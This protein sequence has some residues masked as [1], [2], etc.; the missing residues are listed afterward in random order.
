[1][2]SYISNK[3]KTVGAHIK[4]QASRVGYVIAGQRD[5]TQRS[6]FNG[7]MRVSY[8]AGGLVIN[9]IGHAGK[10]LVGKRGDWQRPFFADGWDIFWGQFGRRKAFERVEK[11]LKAQGWPQDKEL[12]IDST[13]FEHEFKKH[14]HLNTVFNIVSL[15]GIPIGPLVSTKI[16]IFKPNP[17][18]WGLAAKYWGQSIALLKPK[19]KSIGVDLADTGRDV[20]RVFN[21]RVI[22]PLRKKEP[23]RQAPNK[24]RKS[25]HF[26]AE[27]AR[28]AFYKEMAKRGYKVP[29]K[30]LEPSYT[31]RQQNK[32]EEMIGYKKKT[33]KLGP[34]KFSW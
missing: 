24:T 15:V 5:T 27:L 28:G 3:A 14:R 4:K 26:R 25:V 34:I 10:K 29:E 32:F 22:A 13:Q 2:K 11:D 9:T 33:V 1:M 19:F 18:T 23:N 16:A 17:A 6:V 8:R 7:V 31:A 20:G 21:N 30:Y 12:D